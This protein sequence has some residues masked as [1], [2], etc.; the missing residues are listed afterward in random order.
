MSRGSVSFSENHSA[1][2]PQSLRP[3]QQ[4]SQQ[5][6]V[7]YGETIDDRETTVDM[8]QLYSQVRETRSTAATPTV[9]GSASLILNDLG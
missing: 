1:A 8:L 2:T 7:S 3:G 9:A 4:S 6:G 5:L